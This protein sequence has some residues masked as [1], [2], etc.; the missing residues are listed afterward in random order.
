VRVELTAVAAE[1]LAARLGAD[2][3][4]VEG[5]VRAR[6]AEQVELAVTTTLLRSGGEQAWRGEVVAI[7]WTGV[8]RVGERTFSRRRTALAAAALVGAATV[9]ALAVGPDFSL[10]GRGRGG[11][12]P[13][14]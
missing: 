6:D 13:D 12:G 4:A 7:P 10:A 11:T 14:R 1:T 2:V 9:A 5:H 8:A 3:R